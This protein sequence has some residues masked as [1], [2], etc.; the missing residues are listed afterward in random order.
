M[1]WCHHLIMLV[2]TVSRQ[3]AEV[4]RL[5]YAVLGLAEER[6]LADKVT[7]AVQDAH[8]AITVLAQLFGA[9]R[10]P[11]SSLG[12]HLYWLGYRY[13]RG[14]HDKYASDV[15][16]L[17]SSSHNGSGPFLILGWRRPSI[18]PGPTATSWLSS[19]TPSSTLSTGCATSAES[20][21]RRA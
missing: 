8:Q 6:E 14:E 4:N 17:P 1:P 19:G 21:R 3:V 12:Q 11:K 2:G 10:L 18:G 13:A 7:R 5:V 20:I 9:D 16:P 15:R